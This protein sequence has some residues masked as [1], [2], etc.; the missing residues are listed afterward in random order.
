VT[1]A[2]EVRVTGRVQGVSFRWYA[3]REAE[4][5]GLA[6][7]VR[8]EPDGSVA[9]RIEG[10]D[11][12]VDELVAWFGQGPRAARVDDLQLRE[13]PPTGASSFEVDT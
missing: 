10:P 2:V 4:R 11:D 6:G 1:R 5:L 3:V 7:W 13:V 9:A 8:N 12:A